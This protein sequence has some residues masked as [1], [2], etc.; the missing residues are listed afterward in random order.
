M[1]I[2]LDN[3]VPYR[4]KQLFPGHAVMHTSDVGFEAL[5]NGELLAG[6]AQALCRMGDAR[7]AGAVCDT[8]MGAE[9][10]SAYR[11]QARGEWM[12]ACR[13]KLEEHCFARAIFF[14]PSTA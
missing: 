10:R 3:C 6:R 2:L 1:R 12:L 11:W 14:K 8:A 7:Q 9:G 13:Q 5:S 4:A